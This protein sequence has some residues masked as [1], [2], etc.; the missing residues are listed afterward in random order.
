M[1]RQFRHVKLLK[2]AG[3]ANERDGILTTKPGGLAVVCPAC[4]QPGVNL[5]D[6]WKEVE[7]SKK[8]VR[9]TKSLLMD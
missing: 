7:A 2:K 6:N 5:P 1:I 4:P 8:Y 3:R 9:K